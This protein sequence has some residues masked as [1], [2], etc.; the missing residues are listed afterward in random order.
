MLY[1]AA[2]MAA[3]AVGLGI[4]ASSMPSISATYASAY[5]YGLLGEISSHTG[6]YVSQFTAFVPKSFCA[7]VGNGSVANQIGV[8]VSVANSTI[9]SG[10]TEAIRMQY[11][12]GVYVLS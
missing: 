12:D 6:Y 9:C 10:K 11:S 2:G 7:S 1:S 8:P 3:L 5:W 4:A